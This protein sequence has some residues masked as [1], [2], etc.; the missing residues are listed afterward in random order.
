MIK[1]RTGKVNNYLKLDRMVTV[2]VPVKDRK[3]DHMTMQQS[4]RSGMCNAKLVK[5][6]Y[7]RSVCT[8]RMDESLHYNSKQ[9]CFL[10]FFFLG[11]STAFIASSNTCFSPFWVRALHSTYFTACM[12][13]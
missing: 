2:G 8:T 10:S 9:G 11:S 1:H 13:F 5:S 7:G 6:T 4:V 12:S 3:K